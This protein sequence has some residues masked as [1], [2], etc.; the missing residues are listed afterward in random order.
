MH[1]AQ[2]NVANQVSKLNEAVQSL[3]GAGPG[4]RSRTR[5]SQP[6]IS[7]KSLETLS[8]DMGNFMRDMRS[9]QTGF[10]RRLSDLDDRI[11]HERETILADLKSF[12]EDM[13]TERQEFTKEIHA[14]RQQLGEGSGETQKISDLLAKIDEKIKELGQMIED[15]SK[16]QEEIYQQETEGIKVEGKI[17][18]PGADTRKSYP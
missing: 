4:P 18:G 17:S 10:E 15:Q 6:G 11:N 2:R 16:R 9:R 14:S 12:M 3:Q 1:K 13:H 5:A 7:E 8:M